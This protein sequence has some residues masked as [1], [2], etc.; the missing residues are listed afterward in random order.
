MQRRSTIA[1]LDRGQAAHLVSQSLIIKRDATN[2]NIR[3][4]LQALAGKRLA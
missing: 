2:S 1:F 3:F 4:I